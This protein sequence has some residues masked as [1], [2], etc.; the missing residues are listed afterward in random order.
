VWGRPVGLAVDKDGALLVSED[1]NGTIWRVSFTGRSGPGAVND[2]WRWRERSATG[3]ACTVAALLPID[4]AALNY[5]FIAR[6]RIFTPGYQ[7]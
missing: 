3:T 4:G 5:D 6:Q 1:G 7:D 2:P